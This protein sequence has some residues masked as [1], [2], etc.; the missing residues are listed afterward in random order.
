NPLAPSHTALLAKI[1]ANSPMQAVK[2]ISKLPPVFSTVP[3]FPFSFPPNPRWQAWR[4]HADLTL[5]KLRPCR[6]IAGMKRELDPYAAPT[7]TTSGLPVIGAGGQ[8]NL[9]GVTAI[10]PS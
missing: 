2:I 8:L 6:N 1:A 7:D 9:P 10:R 4:L 3:S 5:Y